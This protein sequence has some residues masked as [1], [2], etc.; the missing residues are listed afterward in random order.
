MYEQTITARIL[1]AVGVALLIFSLVLGWISFAV[2]DWLEYNERI[3]SNGETNINPV[4]FGLWY[5]CIFSNRSN[6]FTC[7]TWNTHIPSTHLLTDRIVSTFLFRLR[8]SG[9][10]LRSTWL[11]VSLLG[12]ALLSDRF[13][14][15]T[16]LRHRCSSLWI[17]RFSQ[18]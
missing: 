13:C 16:L 18:L 2:P 3:N 7:S 17:I 14:F 10:S 4:K 8:S 15:S 6:D 5:K 12:T 11:S 1:L 9:P